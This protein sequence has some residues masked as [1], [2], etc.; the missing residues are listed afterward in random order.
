MFARSAPRR[1]SSETASIS[2]SPNK[3]GVFRW[4][5]T[6]SGERVRERSVSTLKGIEGSR[7]RELCTRFRVSWNSGRI[8]FWWTTP[9]GAPC[10]G[11]TAGQPVDGHVAGDR[12]PRR[13]RLDDGRRGTRWH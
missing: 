11:I 8:A 1:V 13:H 2:P 3:A 7:G 5:I 10:S 12:S 4:V 9:E 6:T